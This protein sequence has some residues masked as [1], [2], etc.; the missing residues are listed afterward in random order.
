ML[1]KTKKE[2]R[3][4]AGKKQYQRL[5]QESIRT[6]LNPKENSILDGLGLV[7]LTEAEKEE[8]MRSGRSRED[9]EAEQKLILAMRRRITDVWLV[10][11]YRGDRYDVLF[12]L[13]YLSV[14]LSFASSWLGWTGK[15]F[16][17]QLAFYAIGIIMTG[18]VNYWLLSGAYLLMLN[19]DPDRNMR[20]SHY[21]IMQGFRGWLPRI[22]RGIMFLIMAKMAFESG[23]NLYLAYALPVSYFL[24]SYAE[25]MIKLSAKKELMRVQ[26]K[27]A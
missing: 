19:V 16:S 14:V 27:Y 22:G 13:A 7:P 17:G 20:L 4:I 5:Y 10:E 24:V 21:A 9:V 23:Y 1:I 18:F 2:E 26:D 25:W 6:A 15:V 11:E 8:R 3:K 12:W